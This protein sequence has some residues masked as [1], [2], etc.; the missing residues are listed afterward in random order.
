[1][2]KV[3]VAAPHGFD[4][5]ALVD[6]LEPVN[7]LRIRDGMAM[8]ITLT[9][10]VGVGISLFLGLRNGLV[11]GNIETIY[12]LRLL[13]LLS[14]GLTAGYAA[15]SMAR[16]AVGGE[17][18]SFESLAWRIALG[19]A[20]AFPLAALANFALDIPRSAEA[21]TSLFVPTVGR[22]CLTFSGMSA[23]MI[24]AAIVTWLRRGAVMAPERAGWLVGLAAGGFG[25]AAYS[26][27]CPINGVIYIGTWYS[28]AVLISAVAGRLIVPRLLRW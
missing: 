17:N 13:A 9:L 16:P 21:M 26:I 8:A 28:L 14:V 25:A 27:Y 23:L 11:S 22:E 24:G 3:A 5:G 10:F 12:V 18:R 1:M 15:M 4:I 20:A 19:L 7:P 2:E 6:D